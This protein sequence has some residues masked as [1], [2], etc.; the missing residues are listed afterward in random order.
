MPLKVGSQT[1]NSLQAAAVTGKEVNSHQVPDAVGF[2][3]EARVPGELKEDIHTWKEIW[4]SG[5]GRQCW[6]SVSSPPNVEPVQ[7]QAKS[8][9]LFVEIDKPILK[10][11]RKRKRPG[12]VKI[13]MKKNKDE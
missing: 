10:H 3:R 6:L 5:T 8:Q 11:K 7:P 1:S 12:I 13:I 4:F 2:R 9:Q